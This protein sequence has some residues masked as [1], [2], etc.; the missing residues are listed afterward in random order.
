MHADT[1]RAWESRHGFPVPVRLPSGHRRYNTAHVDQVREVLDDRQA[2]MSLE[3]AIARLRAHDDEVEPSIFAGL[4]RRRPALPVHVISKRAMLALSRAIE[5]ECCARAARPVLI[6]CFQ[7][8]RFYRESEARWRDLARTAATAMVFADFEEDRRRRGEP[9]RIR[10]ASDTPLL[11]EWAVV[12][13]APDAAACVVGFE[14]PAAAGEPRRFEAVWSVEPAVVHDAA[15]LGVALAGRD[16]ATVPP[17]TGTDVAA[18][19][20]RA[21]AVTSRAISYLDG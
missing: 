7:Q 21:A 18:T 6:G 9:Q 10:L 2:G 3:A 5:D 17:T 1:L 11:R 20:Q 16:A 15:E 8:E 19:L 14:R 12:C 4:R 13:A